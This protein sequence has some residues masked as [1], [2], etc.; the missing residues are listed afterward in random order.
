MAGTIIATTRG[1][2][3]VG[4]PY[5]YDMIEVRLLCTCEAAAATF[6]SVVLNTLSGVVGYDLVGYKLYSVKA[7]PG[8]TG[9]TDATDLTITDVDG[10]DLLGARGTNLIM[11]ATKTSC[12][13]GSASSEMPMPITGPITINISNNAVNA[14]VINLKLLFTV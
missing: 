12:C 3:K 9:P 1:I 2:K 10:V 13:A 7:F 6:T 14:A 5:K 11:E 4:S 8:S